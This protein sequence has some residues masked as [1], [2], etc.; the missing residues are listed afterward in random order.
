MVELANKFGIFRVGLM[1]LGRYIRL[2]ELVQMTEQKKKELTFWDRE[3]GHWQYTSFVCT[4]SSVCD[5]SN[6]DID[7][8]ILLVTSGNGNSGFVT[9]SDNGDKHHTLSIW[10]FRRN[11]IL[12]QS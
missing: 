8:V 10:T 6:R 3:K 4:P 5:V 11:R 1:F 9:P 2:R 12:W 7:R